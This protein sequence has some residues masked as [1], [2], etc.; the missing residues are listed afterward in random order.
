MTN[1]L[2][3]NLKQVLGWHKLR[4]QCLVQIVLGLIAVRTVNL[5]ELACFF[6]GAAELDSTY[7]RLQRFFAE[8]KFP[9]HFIAQFV[10]GLF[11]LPEQ[12]FFLSIDRTNWCWGKANINILVL[13]ACYRG[14]AIPL[15]WTALDKKGNSDTRER[16]TLID[17]FIMGFG[18]ERILGLLGDREFIGEDWFSYLVK[19]E[20]P[21]DIRVKKNHVTTNSRGLE[22]DI[23]GLFYHLTPGSFEVLKGKRKLMGR[24]VYLSGLRLEDGELLILASSEK[25]DGALDRYAKR[26]E[27]ETLFSCLKGRGFCFESTRI[28]ELERIEKMV[29]VLAIAFAWAHKIGD[30]KDAEVKPLKVK[31]H[32]RLAMSYFRY[33][34][35]WIRQTLVG[36]NPNHAQLQKCLSILMDSW[37]RIESKV[38][39]GNL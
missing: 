29:S 7:R 14:S 39:F 20:I 16:I 31:K 37:P 23:D 8:V 2:E 30:W 6:S 35:D 4:V 13:S 12:G 27:I 22:V 38:V 17:H 36:I 25:P 3:D 24:R 19:K 32:G 26:W 18:K 15:Y 21:F 9:K 1:E 10:A 33:G 5:K 28:T 11:Y 34:L